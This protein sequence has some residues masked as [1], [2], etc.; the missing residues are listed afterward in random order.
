MLIKH[1]HHIRWGSVGEGWVQLGVMAR[2]SRLKVRGMKI[3][4][5]Q[6]DQVQWP[7]RRGTI[8]NWNT[9][10]QWSVAKEMYSVLHTRSKISDF[11][12]KVFLWEGRTGTS[13]GSCTPHASCCRQPRWTSTGSHRMSGLP[14]QMR[15]LFPVWMMNFIIPVQCYLQLLPQWW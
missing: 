14:S 1:T 6:I 4:R 3:V 2:F 9:H 12:W 11:D 5:H 7:T 8:E 15:L 10:T 13:A